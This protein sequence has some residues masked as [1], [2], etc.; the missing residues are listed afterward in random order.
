MKD[1]VENDEIH[2]DFVDPEPFVCGPDETWEMPLHILN[3]V[4]LR[5][6]WIVNIYNDDF[7]IRLSLVK[8][9]HY[10]ENLDLLDLSDV[11][12]L[13]ANLT[14]VERVIVAVSLCLSMNLSRVFPGLMHVHQYCRPFQ[15]YHVRRKS[16]KKATGQVF[17]PEGMLRSS[18]YSH[19]EGNNCEQT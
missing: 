10:T 7:P 14:H 2:T 1:I 12:K 3:V 18:R 16:L 17:S 5:S 15:N 19:G 11:P 13:L 9:S 6:Q 4:E 8:Q